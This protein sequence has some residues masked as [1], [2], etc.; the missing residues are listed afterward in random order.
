MGGLLALSRMIDAVTAFIGRHIIWLILAAILVSA[1]NAIIRK[2]FDISS[3]A[4]LELQWYLF[5]AVFMLAAA[6]T[7]QKNEH[8]RIDIISG[9][10]SQNTRNGIDI[11]GHVL[12]L[13]PFTALM[14]YE[15]VPF[16]LYALR[17]GEMSGSAGGLIIWPARA[18]VL[19]GFFLLFL[20]G[21]SELIKR[22]A[23]MRGLIPDPHAGQ[24]HQVPIE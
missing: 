18:F 6:Y 8:I 23:V 11:A 3:N 21:I 2:A 10:L 12:M 13:L 24:G 17:S 7:L 15:S 4:W 1:V 14:I 16:V 9:R 19:A 22:I 20:Q 5:G